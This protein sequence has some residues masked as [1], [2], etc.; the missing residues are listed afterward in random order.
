MKGEFCFMKRT[1]EFVLVIIGALL[2]AFFA[3]MGGILIW[4]Q[5]NQDVMRDAMEEADTEGTGFSMADF[6]SMIEGIGNSGWQLAIFSVIAVILG[7]VTLVFLKG[8]KK[9]KAAG[10]IL[11]ATAVVSL[12]VLGFGTWIIAIFYVIAGIMALARK[13]KPIIEG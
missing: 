13:P 9:P 6:N 8:N 5:N 2:Y 1:G 12:F 11:I 4:I 3:A 7:I 10:I